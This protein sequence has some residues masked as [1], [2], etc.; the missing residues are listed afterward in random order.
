MATVY[1]ALDTK[2]LLKVLAGF[3]QHLKL[4]VAGDRHRPPSAYL[5]D[6]IITISQIIGRRQ[7]LSL[8]K[9]KR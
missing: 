2:D 3:E 8:P 7:P 5:A 6:R 1:D 9:R 4:A